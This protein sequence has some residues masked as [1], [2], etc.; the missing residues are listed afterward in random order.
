MNI[1]MGVGT[2]VAAGRIVTMAGSG[3]CIVVSLGVGDTAVGLSLWKTGAGGG[4]A[5]V[6]QASPFKARAIMRNTS[7]EG[8]AARES[9]Q[10]LP[11][12]ICR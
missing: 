9:I 2:P 6:P 7:F 3:T 12:A 1:T 11:Y 10:L 4:A 5:E 8:A